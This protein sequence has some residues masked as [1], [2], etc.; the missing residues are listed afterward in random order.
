MHRYGAPAVPLMEDLGAAVGGLTVFRRAARSARP[1][2]LAAGLAFYPVVGLALGLVA[3]GA[4]WLL[5]SGPAGVLVLLALGGGWASYGLAAAAEAALGA[6]GG[7]G[8]LVRLRAAPGWAGWGVAVVALALRLWAAAILPAPACTVALVLAPMLGAWAIVVQCY[9]GAP[10]QARGHARAV[11]GRARFRE[12]GWASLLA[13]GVT[14][15]M[16]EAIG[17]VVLLA[18]ALTT[19]A[20]R[21]LAHRR[22]GGLTG[23]LLAAT[24]ELVETMVLVTLAILWR[25]RP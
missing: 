19:L 14:L 3:A 1:E 13:F 6:G 10:T 2:S 4:A 22:V 7:S 16:G 20:V 17:L 23:R 25:L 18:A 8:T 11:I 21:V 12:F 24:R 5:S 15:G 9:G